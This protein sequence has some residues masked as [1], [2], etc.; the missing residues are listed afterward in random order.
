MFY[1]VFIGKL[2]GRPFLSMSS[3]RS[4]DAARGAR[5]PDYQYIGVVRMKEGRANG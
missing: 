1:N 5:A 3:F 2:T 4:A